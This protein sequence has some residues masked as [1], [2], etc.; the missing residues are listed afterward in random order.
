MSHRLPSLA[1]GLAVFGIAA[2]TALAQ[3]PEP[4]APT[5]SP[6][7][8]STAPDPG[9]DDGGTTASGVS[10][11]DLEL[12]RDTIT[13]GD[14]IRA[15]LTLVWMGPEPSAPPRFPTWQETWGKA[16]VLE[17]S[18]IERFVDGSGRAIHRQVLTLTAFEVGTIDLPP[19]SFAVPL[20]E[21]TEELHG[22]EGE[23]FEV[24]SVLPEQATADGDPAAGDPAAGD[25]AAGDPAAG[26][27][28]A[29]T[30]EL[31]PRPAAPPLRLTPNPRVPWVFAG[32]GLATLMVAFL[33]ARRLD[34]LPASELDGTTPIKPLLPPLEELHVSLDL[35]DPLAGSEPAHTALSLALRR[36]LGRRLGFQAVESTTSEIQRR[37]R[38]L[39]LAGDEA[40]DLVRLLRECDAVK[41]ARLEV[42][43]TVSE[44]R[45]GRARRL[46][47]KIEGHFMPQVFEP[48]TLDGGSTGGGFAGGAPPRTISGEVS[49]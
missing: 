5:S 14:Q 18:E 43:A 33:L 29:E 35:V 47:E 17:A 28:A 40:R 30:A 36:Y 48:H 23:R 4:S 2:L 42:S 3:P 46:A 7:T 41:F 10:R 44:E 11:I 21:T 45:L 26:D 19:V 31:E 16:E 1:A 20:G 24:V 32:L 15:E 37:T 8:V 12:D 34:A 22:P 49:A 13:V 9:A 38:Q 39:P 6:A 27:P 25:P